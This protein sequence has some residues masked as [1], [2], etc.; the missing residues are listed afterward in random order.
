MDIKKMKKLLKLTDKQFEELI[1]SVNA[2]TNG[3]IL[4]NKYLIKADYEDY[5]ISGDG[6]SYEIIDLYEIL[7][8]TYA[9]KKS[10]QKRT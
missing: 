6:Y 3:V 1:E 9:R 4:N 7:H 5:G 8:I 2:K 10:V